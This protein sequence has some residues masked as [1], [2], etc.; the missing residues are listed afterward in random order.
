MV[1]FRVII[2]YKSKKYN[3]AIKTLWKA[4][5]LDIFYFKDIRGYIYNSV[6]NIYYKNGEF[7]DAGEFY[8]KSIGI[9]SNGYELW[10]M[11][12][13]SYC[14]IG[15]YDK[16]K[17]SYLKANKLNPEDKVSLE[18]IEKLNPI[19]KNKEKEEA[20]KIEDNIIF[21]RASKNHPYI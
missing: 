11:L 2:L 17:K 3:E 16:A 21:K 6:N 8:L 15:Q 10:V 7:K 5:K 18:M 13:N 9:S 4:A 14:E 12:G 20:E 1:L 19:L